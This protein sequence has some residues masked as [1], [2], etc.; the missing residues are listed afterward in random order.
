MQDPIDPTIGSNIEDMNFNLTSDINKLDIILRNSTNC[1]PQ[2]TFQ[3]M[4]SNK[5]SFDHSHLLDNS[6][7][8]QSNNTLS[9]SSNK[10][11]TQI[12]MIN[13]FIPSKKISKSMLTSTVKIYR[14]HP[15]HHVE[16]II[17]ITIPWAIKILMYMNN[18][19][20]FIY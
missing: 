12:N 3:P 16:M 15:I 19:H 20:Q 14:M 9:A 11:E 18:I 13:I 6:L 8:K 10:I 7:D 17:Q 5:V 1:E 2:S 4:L